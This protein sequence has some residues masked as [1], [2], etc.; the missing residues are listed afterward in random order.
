MA[1]DRLWDN[2]GDEWSLV[3]VGLTGAEVED[4]LRS[5]CRI[6]RHDDWGGPLV[7][8]TSEEGWRF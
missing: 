4:Q 3:S 8:L 6:A 7:F 5:G 2:V 1:D